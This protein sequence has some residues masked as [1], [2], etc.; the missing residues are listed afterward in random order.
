MLTK[1]LGSIGFST[2]T[3]YMDSED[4]TTDLQKF[5]NGRFRRPRLI[6][7]TAHGGERSNGLNLYAYEFPKVPC[8]FTYC[9]VLVCLL[10]FAC[11]GRL[12]QVGR[13]VYKAVFLKF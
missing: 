13:L 1:T 8:Y 7:V 12:G 9:F 5:L 6:F 4:F 2:K 3:L 11:N 10:T